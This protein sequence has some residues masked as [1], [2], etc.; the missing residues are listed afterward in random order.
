MNWSPAAGSMTSSQGSSVALARSRPASR[1]ASG[2]S[3]PG[4]SRTS[5]LS[6]DLLRSP[7]ALEDLGGSEP[8]V[9]DATG[10]T[11]ELGAVAATLRT[12]PCVTVAVAPGSSPEQAPAWVAPFDVVVTEDEV[13]DLTAGVRRS[14]V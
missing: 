6:V 5:R 3:A 2:P 14:P 1:S 8:F 11:V 13:D 7:F 9:V 10:G 12:L 4:S